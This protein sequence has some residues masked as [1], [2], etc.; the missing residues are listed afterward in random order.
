ML[1]PALEYDVA[2]VIQATGSAKGLVLAKVLDRKLGE[3]GRRIFDEVAEDRLF[4]VSDQVDLV[5]RGD[6]VDGSQAVPDD[7]VAGNIE[8]RLDAGPTS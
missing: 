2:E 7:G 3:L 8:E 6:F 1:R 4:V 5:D